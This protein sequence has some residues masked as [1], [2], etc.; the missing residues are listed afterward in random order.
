MRIWAKNLVDGKIVKDFI[1]EIDSFDVH[2][3]E[4]YVSYACEKLDN[5]T[6]IV[7][8]KHIKNFILFNSAVFSP[9]EFVESYHYDKFEVALIPDK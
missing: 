1:F 6:P 5:P 3:F 4:S 9:D 7:L 8:V 2:K